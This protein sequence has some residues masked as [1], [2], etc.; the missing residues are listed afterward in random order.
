M[1]NEWIEWNGGKCPVAGDVAV[2]VIYQYL[3]NPS[4]DYAR[5]LN[6][7]NTGN[8]EKYCIYQTPRELELEKQLAIAKEVLEFY[9]DW[10]C[11]TNDELIYTNDEGQVDYGI[12]AQQALEKLKG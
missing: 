4:L 8:I 5:R 11:R 2:E 6:F 12:K 1:T 3:S 7:W 9:A 10:E